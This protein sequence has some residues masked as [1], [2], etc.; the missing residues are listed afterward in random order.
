MRRELQNK[1]LKYG[2]SASMSKSKS[3][4]ENLYDLSEEDDLDDK[5]STI[6]RTVGYFYD[7]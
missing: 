5:V 3:S 4:D 7:G 2:Q 6:K 1:K